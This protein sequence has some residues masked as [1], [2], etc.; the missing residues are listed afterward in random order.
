M[1]VDISTLKCK[2]NVR[3][4]SCKE[5]SSFSQG[6]IVHNLIRED[7]YD[8][9]QES[10]AINF[11]CKGNY[12]LPKESGFHSYS[13]KHDILHTP[14]PNGITRIIFIELEKMVKLDVSTESN[15]LMLWVL[16]CLP[17]GRL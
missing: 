11:L 6:Y 14:I 10:I 8:E 4:F 1:K 7:T 13:L 17:A 16:S 15:L 2:L 9:L 3:V 12:G 5:V